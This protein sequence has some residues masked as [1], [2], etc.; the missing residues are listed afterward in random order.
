MG[1]WGTWFFTATKESASRELELYLGSNT[2]S[3]IYLASNTDAWQ[4]SERKHEITRHILNILAGMRFEYLL[5]STRSPL[6]TRD[7]DL[8]LN[9]DG[10]VEV[11]VSIPTD[12]EHIRKICEPNAPSIDERIATLKSLKQSGLRTRAHIA[13]LL[14]HSEKFI[15]KLID[16]TDSIWVDFPDARTPTK[17]RL[18][19]AQGWSQ[20]L[21]PSFINNCYAN[22]TQSFPEHCFSF[23]QEGF[24]NL[25]AIGSIKNC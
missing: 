1:R 19:H 21:C 12:L 24:F 5:C 8:L 22:F 15:D 23:G 4:P 7:I 18:Y 11:G 9:L 13:P 10:M 3:K 16:V 25:K 14:P 20:W 17:E 6:I 2:K